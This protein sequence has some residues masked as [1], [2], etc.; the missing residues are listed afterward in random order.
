M[1]YA[2]IESKYVGET[3]KNII[4]LF[5]MAKEKDVV[6]LF[7]EADALLSKRVSG[8]THHLM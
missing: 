1:N 6:I 2:E 8:C 5:D 4:S 7:D 3:S